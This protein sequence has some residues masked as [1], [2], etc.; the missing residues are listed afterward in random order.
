MTI[1]LYQFEECPYCKEV[2]KVLEKKKVEYEVVNV[3]FDRDDK[4]R[5]QL[6][7]RAGVNTVPVLDVDG[8]FLGESG[9]IIDFLEKNY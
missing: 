3:S 7:Q 1:K 2:R 9:K 6:A 4:V 8:S 5:Q